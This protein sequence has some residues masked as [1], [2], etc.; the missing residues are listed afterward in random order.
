MSCKFVVTKNSH[1]A[2]EIKRKH[3]R[4]IV[5]FVNNDSSCVIKPPDAYC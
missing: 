1:S 4:V 2:G 3:F 5:M